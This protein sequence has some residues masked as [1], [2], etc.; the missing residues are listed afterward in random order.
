MIEDFNLLLKIKRKKFCTRR[1]VYLKLCLLETKGKIDD[2]NLTK[3]CKNYGTL[4]I[5]GNQSDYGF[6]GLFK[7]FDF[8]IVRNKFYWKLIDQAYLFEACPDL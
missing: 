4:L 6:F 8:L 3:S 7:L 2:N 5:N 1:S